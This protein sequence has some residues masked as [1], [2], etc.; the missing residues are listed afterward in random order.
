[1]VVAEDDSS[2]FKD[3]LVGQLLLGRYRVVRKLAA[4]GMGVVYLARSEGAAGFVKPV[5][6]KVVL[7]SFASDRDFAGMFA[8][9]ANILSN[10][11]DPGIVD[12]IEFAAEDH[13]YLMIMEYVHGFQVREWV[14]FLRQK[15]QR[16][17]VAIAI[18]I[19]ISVLDALDHAHGLTNPDGTS[20]GIV[21]RDISPSNI[22][23]DTDGRIKLVDFGIAVTDSSSVDYHTKAGAFKG[24]LSYSAP[25]LF[26]GNK[27]SVQSDVYSCG[28]T[29]HELLLGKND[30]AGR[31][32]A[33]TLRN[34]LTQSPRPIGASRK[35]E[36][37]G[38]NLII[39]KALAKEPENRFQ[40]AAGFASALRNIHRSTERETIQSLS[41]ILQ[42]DF[43]DE[44]A[45][46]LGVESL[47][48][49]DRAWRFPSETPEAPLGPTR[50][51]APASGHR[52]KIPPPI[53]ESTPH[54]TD[55]TPY[56]KDTVVVS[57][58]SPVSST[59]KHMLFSKKALA[60]GATLFVVCVSAV[61]GI[62][63]FTRGAELKKQP[64]FFLVQ[65]P[66]DSAETAVGKVPLKEEDPDK[67][68]TD[69]LKEDASIKGEKAATV[70]VP[71]EME[72]KRPVAKIS[73]RPKK[74]RGPN[75]IALTNA[76]RRKESQIRTC[77]KDHSNDLVGQPKISVLFKVMSS[78]KVKAATLMPKTIAS[79][80]LGGCLRL[81]AM[82]TK[83]PS[84]KEEISF[85]IPV[86][87]QRVK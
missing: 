43:G 54:S 37:R 81:V 19:V 29:L 83:F 2:T 18:Q 65:A 38:V 60:F 63:V 45:D 35:G 39:R 1:M 53:A 16:I 85:R 3:Y 11:K 47:A 78:G 77:F 6:V 52:I 36:Y 27:A 31:D 67:F 20:M 26:S 55:S 12:V 69:W 57:D 79:T 82:S 22:M 71:Q 46:Y 44:M 25:E 21:H 13:K 28:V 42:K 17:P 30:F 76:F 62:M 14:R 75:V 40:S 86:T 51:T 87:A 32:E 4:G 74:A 9:E 66:V 70:E 50:T 59:K 73:N 61:V 5:V 24:K 10:L 23:I 56:T 80:A 8:R 49:R 15:K 58:N 64:Q 72:I 68:S 7:P 34:V 33:S 41:Q 84:Q 48:K